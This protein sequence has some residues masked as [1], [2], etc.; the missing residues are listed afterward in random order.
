MNKKE[1]LNRIA[2]KEYDWL[3]GL[4]NYELC[5]EY[6]GWFSLDEH[7]AQT[8]DDDLLEE[9]KPKM[10]EDYVSDYMRYREGES[11]EDLQAILNE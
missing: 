9:R 7:D 2:V 1:L 3:K 6:N 5:K 10:Y 8:E 4:S 11:I